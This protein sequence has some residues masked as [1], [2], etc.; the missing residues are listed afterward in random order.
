MRRPETRTPTAA[1]AIGGKG[2]GGDGGYVNTG[3]DGTSQSAERHV[4]DGLGEHG[5]HLGRQYGVR[6]QRRRLDRNDNETKSIVDNGNKAESD[7]DQDA[8]GGYS[9]AG[10]S[11]HEGDNKSTGG[12]ATNGCGV[13][14]GGCQSSNGGNSSGGGAST[15]T[16]CRGIR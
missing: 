5:E 6:R 2:I 4:I 3:N 8:D 15:P 7:V 10:N 12:D 13:M 1:V 9:A 14:A 11:N 16:R